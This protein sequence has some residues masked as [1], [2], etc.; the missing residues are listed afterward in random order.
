MRHDAFLSPARSPLCLAITG[1]RDGRDLGAFM[2]N[3][4]T[5]FRGRVGASD[6][7]AAG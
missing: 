7:P 6:Q 5:K 3:D 4:L 1:A 2:F